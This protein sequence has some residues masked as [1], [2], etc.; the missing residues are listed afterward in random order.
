MVNLTKANQMFGKL[1]NEL[2]KKKEC[3]KLGTSRG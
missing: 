2:T 1:K 3:E